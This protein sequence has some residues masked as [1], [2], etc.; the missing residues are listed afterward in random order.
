M[1]MLF[2]VA[3]FI[4]QI[5]KVYISAF[6]INFLHCGAMGAYWLKCPPLILWK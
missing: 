1:L 4:P 2:K 3:S 6:L 5:L